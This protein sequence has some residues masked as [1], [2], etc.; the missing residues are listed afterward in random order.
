MILWTIRC[1]CEWSVLYAVHSEI[2][3]YV[4][5]NNSQNGVLHLYSHINI[6]PDFAQNAIQ[7]T[8]YYISILFSVFGLVLVVS[9]NCQ[10]I[11]SLRTKSEIQL[12]TSTIRYCLDCSHIIS[13]TSDMK[14]FR[15][16]QGSSMHIHILMTFYVNGNIT[17][18]IWQLDYFILLISMKSYFFLTYAS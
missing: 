13:Y 11:Y 6:S 15:D 8:V 16:L 9:Q 10:V 2:V 18:F 5:Q 3:K 17:T 14:V 1:I 12:E 7:L 4:S